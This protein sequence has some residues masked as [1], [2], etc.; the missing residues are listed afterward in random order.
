MQTNNSSAHCQLMEVIPFVNVYLLTYLSRYDSVY[1]TI[2]EN[3]FCFLFVCV[4]FWVWIQMEMKSDPFTFVVIRIDGLRRATF[5]SETSEW[6]LRALE[7]T[8]ISDFQWSTSGWCTRWWC[9]WCWCRSTSIK[10]I[11]AILTAGNAF[12]WIFVWLFQ[13][14]LGL[15]RFHFKWTHAID[16]CDNMKFNIER[17]ASKK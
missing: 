2:H 8:T 1:L 5:P 7:R 14:R 9:W 10:P 11:T 6:T 4:L 13:F 16:W 15:F 12:G 17:C 3:S